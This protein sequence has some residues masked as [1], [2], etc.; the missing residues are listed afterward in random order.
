VED[1]HNLGHES[2]GEV[3]RI[4]LTLSTSISSTAILLRYIL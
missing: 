4:T 2:A 1:K 3:Y